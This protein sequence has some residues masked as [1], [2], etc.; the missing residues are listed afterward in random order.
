MACTRTSCAT[1][2]D[3]SKRPRL[4]FLCLSPS[5]SLSL[6]TSTQPP[7]ASSPSHRDTTD[8]LPS[9][10]D[11]SLSA[12]WQCLMV[13]ASSTPAKDGK[14]HARWICRILV[15]TVM[16]PSLLS[17]TELQS[18]SSPPHDPPDATD[19]SSVVTS[20]LTRRK[21]SLAA[22]GRPHD[23]SVTM[24]WCVSGS[25]CGC[26]GC[27]RG[28]RWSLSS[29]SRNC[30]NARLMAGTNEKVRVR[31]AVRWPPGMVWSIHTSDS[32]RMARLSRGSRALQA[33]IMRSCMASTHTTTRC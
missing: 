6:S 12:C 26:G 23:R 24:G 7:I 1:A 19:P 25:G 31:A 32:P 10:E 21:S 4:R 22:S 3:M 30:A 18:M 27:G 8:A 11:T 9:G 14:E 20:L 15:P 33:G 17:C 2:A 16:S 5:L 28:R 13:G 29:R